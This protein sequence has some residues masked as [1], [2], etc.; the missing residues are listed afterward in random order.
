MSKTSRRNVAT[1]L[2]LSIAGCSLTSHNLPSSTYKIE[3]EEDE[4]GFFSIYVIPNST[5]AIDSS[6][7]KEYRRLWHREAKLACH[8]SYAGDP[9]ESVTY[10]SNTGPID[11]IQRENSKTKPVAPLVTV[12]KIGGT[13]FC[14]KKSK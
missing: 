3:K 6:T 4:F 14:S 5:K 7:R 8:G 9:V 12:H 1:A 11:T 2:L 10:D 13:A